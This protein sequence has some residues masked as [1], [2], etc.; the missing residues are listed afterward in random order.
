[1]PWIST[2]ISV[3]GSLLGGAMSDS[4]SG[5]AADAGAASTAEAI[6]EQRRQFDITQQNNA[7]FLNT[8]KAANA[9]LAA[10]LGV[11]PKQTTAFTPMGLEEFSLA[12][13]GKYATSADTRAGYQTYLATN[14]ATESADYSGEYGDL[15]RK[16]TKE[17]LEADPVYQSG[18]EF[19]LKEGEGA[20]N[21]RALA[22]GGYDSG[23]TLKALT[24]FGNDYGSTKANDSYN[25]YNADNTN[26]YNRLAGVSGAGQNAAQTVA[27]AGANSTG[28]ISNLMTDAGNARAAGIVG[29]ANAYSNAFGGVNQALNNYN[30]NKVLQGLIGNRNGGGSRN[31]YNPGGYDQYSALNG[32]NE[33]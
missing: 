17:D 16:F 10:L 19:G 15:L 12:N 13:I 11:G 22:G 23:A 26:V 29:G 1:M 25:R 18:L 27:S 31:Y 30:S 4:A 20:I 21:A 14:P 3:G 7:P 5:R 2:A 24:R 32:S 8:G 33:W 6:A 28:A 9:R